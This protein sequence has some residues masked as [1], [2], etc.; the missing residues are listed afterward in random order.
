LSAQAILEEAI[1]RGVS[2]RLSG[3]SLSLK[4]VTKPPPDFLDKL[5]THKAEIVA[6]LRNEA[7]VEPDAIGF[8]KRRAMTTVDLES[9]CV[10]SEPVSPQQLTQPSA[11][12]SDL[13]ATE[14]DYA[15]T[16]IRYAKQDRLGLTLRNGWLVIGVGSKSDTDLLA[17]LRVHEGAV[18]KSLAQKGNCNR[19]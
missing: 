10:S 14:A 9:P 1:E 11:C 3:N 19:Q 5:R 6:Q 13:Y 4:A 12:F 7:S 16:L 17:E 8:E 18:I 2:V 15:E